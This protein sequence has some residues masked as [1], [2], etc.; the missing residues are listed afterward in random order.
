MTVTYPEPPKN[1]ME[2]SHRFAT[3]EACAEYLFGLRYL[4]GYVCMKCGSV[5]AWHV[6]EKPGMMICENNHKVSVTAGTSLARTK[7]PLLLWF[8]A[9][10]LVATLKPGISALQLQR[11]LGIK[12]LE[13]AWTM[14]HKLRSG[15]I[16]PD[17]SKLTSHCTDQLHTDHWIE[18]DE[19]LVGGKEKG[20]EHR[21]GGA[22]TK[23]L[24]AVAVEVHGWYGA[25]DDCDLNDTKRRT[26][27]A[28]HT[29]AGRCRMNIITD[30]TAKTLTEFIQLNIA[31]GSTIWTDASRSY[32]QS[33]RMGYV[34]RTTVAKDDSDPLP[35]L[36]RVTT[37]LKRWLI[38]THKGAVQSQHLQ[39]YL[40]EFVFRFNRRDIPWIAFNRVLCLAVL[41]RHAVQYDELYKHTWIHPTTEQ[42]QL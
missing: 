17:R 18:V 2:F 20:V 16:A 21:G 5:R 22:E 7:Q 40:N 10:W 38:G 14:L 11:Q 31:L 19:V 24:V 28:G 39:A 34:R 3:E 15:L 35:T 4:D 36:G 9:A 27:A 6:A 29:R 26:R 25:P 42:S 13:T 12:R 41:N 30:T 23:T 32:N 1:I 37:N 33:E 8:H